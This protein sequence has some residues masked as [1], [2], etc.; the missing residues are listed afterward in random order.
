GDWRV[1]AGDWRLAAGGWR[2]ATGG[3][4][5]AAGGFPSRDGGD[6]DDGDCLQRWRGLYAH[7]GDCLLFAEWFPRKA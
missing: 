3:W 1:A 2:L 6:N 7:S 5:L 4:R